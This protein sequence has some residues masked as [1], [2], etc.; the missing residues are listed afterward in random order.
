MSTTSSQIS[1]EVIALGSEVLLRQ[2][3]VDWFGSVLHNQCDRR[4]SFARSGHT[5]RNLGFVHFAFGMAKSNRN[6]SR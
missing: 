2:V 3:A 1:I 5:A 4:R 6:E